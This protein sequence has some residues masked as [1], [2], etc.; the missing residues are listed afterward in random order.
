MTLVWD[1]SIDFFRENFL[2][3]AELANYYSQVN[4]KYLN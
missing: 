1:A 3:P 2:K 4:Q